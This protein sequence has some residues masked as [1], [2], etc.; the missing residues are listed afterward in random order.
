MLAKVVSMHVKTHRNVVCSCYVVLC[1]C[2]WDVTLVWL[3]CVC[4]CV[5]VVLCCVVT[6]KC[7]YD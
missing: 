3:C 5:C 4:V 7:V 1:S 2:A 6:L